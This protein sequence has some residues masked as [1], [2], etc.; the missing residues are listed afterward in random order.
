MY[1]SQKFRNMAMTQSFRN[2]KT[3]FIFPQKNN[4]VTTTT[5]R[6]IIEKIGSKS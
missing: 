4:K 3:G 6:K 5:T 2:G 1:Y